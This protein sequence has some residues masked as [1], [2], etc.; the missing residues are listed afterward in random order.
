M[1]QAFHVH[2]IQQH[3]GFTLIEVLVAVVVLS[4]GLLGLAGLQVTALRNNQSSFA[5]SQ[6]TIFAYDMADRM[7]ANGSAVVSGNYEFDGTTTPTANSNCT[8]T[9]GCTSAEMAQDDLYAWST[10]ISTGL[11][12][13]SG[14]V[15]LDSTPD[16]ANCDGIG[17]QFV[18]SINWAETGDG[19]T[20]NFVT[21]FQP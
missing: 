18:I 16:S 8:G 7:R 21:C 6:A 5:R 2:R 20:S 4:I 10:A 19:S 13:G 12:G 14:T 1:K 3:K 11:P 9:I 17:N 15:C